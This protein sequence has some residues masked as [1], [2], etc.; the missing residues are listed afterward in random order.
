MNRFDRFAADTAP[1]D[2]PEPESAENPKADDAADYRPALLCNMLVRR[3]Q[4]E[5][6]LKHDTEGWTFELVFVAVASGRAFFF[7]NDTSCAVLEPRKYPAGNALHVF[8]AAGTLKG[9][10]ELY[11]NVAQWGRQAM[12]LRRMTTLGRRGFRRA[13]KRHG[14]K[15]PHVWLV[16]DIEGGELQ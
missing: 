15:E 14:W 4:I 12:D 10:L 13:L 1:A 9:L 2:M 11:E 16:K 3:P 6:A 5:K 7:W 8:L